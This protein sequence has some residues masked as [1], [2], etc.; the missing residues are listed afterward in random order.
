M[1]KVYIG[2]GS[3]LGDRQLNIDKALEKL[4]SKKKYSVR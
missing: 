4:K 3:N 1:S 2:I